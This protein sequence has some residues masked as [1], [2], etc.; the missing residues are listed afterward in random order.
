MR[1]NGSVIRTRPTLL[2][3]VLSILAL[4]VAGS[5]RGAGPT[6]SEVKAAF[7]YKFTTYTDWPASMLPPGAVPI[8]IG[9]FADEAFAGTLISVVGTNRVRGR[10]LTVRRLASVEETQGCHLI[11]VAATSG[12]Q[13]PEIVNSVRSKPVLL[14]GEGDKFCRD[15]GMIALRPAGGKMRFEVNAGRVLSAGLKISSQVIQLSMPPEKEAGPPRV[16]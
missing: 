8:V 3:L 7:L 9:V 10:P 1:A 6:E 15:G 16:Q 13:L 11:F 12:A 14:V 5:G 2:V 4:L